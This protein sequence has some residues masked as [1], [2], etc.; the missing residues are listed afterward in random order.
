M[1]ESV[2]P[3]RKSKYP[4]ARTPLES[5][6]F[7]VQVRVFSEK[8]NALLTHFFRATAER[9]RTYWLLASLARH[10]SVRTANAMAFDLFLALVPMLGLAG[11]TAS[12]V[13]RSRSEEIS[14]SAFLT[15]LTPQQ[16]DGFIGQHFD[17]MARAHLA[18]F[19]AVAGWWLVSSAFATM[20][21]VFEETFDCRER[22]WFEKRL[23][24]LALALF[25]MI[26]LGVGGGIGVLVTVT[27]PQLLR[28]IF[29]SL[30]Y[31]GLIK[32]AAMVVTLVIT[33]SFFA[34][35]YR[36]AISRPGTKRRIWP[37][38][39]TASLLGALATVG[40]GFYA[41]NIARYALFYG[42]LAAIIVVL[43]WLWLWSTAILIGAELNIALE[44]VLVARAIHSDE[45][46]A[47]ESAA[48]PQDEALASPNEEESASGRR[49][50]VGPHA[51]SEI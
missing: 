43:L 37:G 15:N 23:V 18:P 4:K 9:T 51:D 7:E 10:H 30:K 29:D 33:A 16:I 25:G 47:E 21:G 39:W 32:A 46:K 3:S 13:V 17:A 2:P 22:S 1:S 40:L 12:A 45:E 41:A 36:Y 28:P 20:M 5:D 26:V 38:A 50:R 42:G 35:I 24:A 8:Y 14:T 27:P 11:W 34:V 31:L 48:I 19:A 49:A 6:D 44:D